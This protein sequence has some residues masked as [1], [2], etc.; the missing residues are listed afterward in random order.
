MKNVHK[1]GTKIC[2]AVFL[3]TRFRFQRVPVGGH[4]C[5]EISEAAEAC[6]VLL[7]LPNFPCP[8]DIYV[9]LPANCSRCSPVSIVFCDLKRARPRC[10]TFVLVE[11]VL[12]RTSQQTSNGLG[13]SVCEWTRLLVLSPLDKMTSFYFIEID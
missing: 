10:L 13:W 2:K 9:F 7:C 1:S 5:R 6:R 12:V 8:C 4:R 3:R 11:V